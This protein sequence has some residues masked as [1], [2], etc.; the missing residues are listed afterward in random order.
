[1]ATYRRGNSESSTYPTSHPT[2]NQAYRHISASRGSGV[3]IMLDV[4]EFCTGCAQTS[5][6]LTVD[7]RLQTCSRHSGDSVSSRRSLDQL[8]VQLKKF[9]TRLLPD[10][11]PSFSGVSDQSPPTIRDTR[12]QAKVRRGQQELY[13]QRSLSQKQAQYQQRLRLQRESL[14]ND[15]QRRANQSFSESNSYVTSSPPFTT[16]PASNSASFHNNQTNNPASSQNDGDYEEVSNLSVESNSLHNPSHDTNDISNNTRRHISISDNN[17]IFKGYNGVLGEL[18]SRFKGD[19]PTATTTAA[20]SSMS[21][22]HIGPKHSSQRSLESECRLPGACLD[23]PDNGDVR[24]F[25]DPPYRR[26]Q[27]TSTAD[28][29]CRVFT[30]SDNRHKRFSGDFALSPSDRTPSQPALTSRPYPYNT[31]QPQKQGPARVPDGESGVRHA[32]STSGLSTS[33]PPI[34][35]RV[36]FSRS[37]AALSQEPSRN[38]PR[39]NEHSHR[40]SATPTIEPI[41]EQAALEAMLAELSGPL[42]SERRSLTRTNSTRS[43][44]YPQRAITNGRV[45]G[46]GRG[47]SNAPDQPTKITT[48]PNS[49]RFV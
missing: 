16:N 21:N 17:P 22:G 18:N 6:R 32:R 35:S 1:M 41:S 15:S 2:L 49:K 37:H 39:Q 24:G 20:T 11:T 8:A 43:R 42:S 9:N 48:T 47:G 38:A 28:I 5:R 23:Y 13:R 30:T 26:V 12:E 19:P 45:P 29:R 44:K 25:G 14:Q 3:D 34:T 33:N 46:I 4:G 36:S 10:S 7:G 31:Q 40:L 27:S